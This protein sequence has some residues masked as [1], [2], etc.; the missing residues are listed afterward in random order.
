MTQQNFRRLIILQWLLGIVSCIVYFATI[1]YLP[2]QLQNYL[3]EIKNAE[4]TVGDWFIFAVGSFLFPIYV[5]IYIGLYRFRKWAKKLLLPI[6]LAS[7]IILPFLGIS[8]QTG[9]VSTINYFYCLVNGGILFLVYWSP[10][11]Q[12]FEN[13]CDV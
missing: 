5:I 1:N 13:N 7:L 3:E 12:M 6:H 8:I 9:A 2:H 11:S 4:P 10:V